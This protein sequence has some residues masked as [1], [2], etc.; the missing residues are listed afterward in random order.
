MT[1]RMLATAAL[2][3]VLAAACGKYG[4]PVRLRSEPVAAGSSVAT[5]KGGAS[6]PEES[7]EKEK[8]P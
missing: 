1:R 2:V 6:T 5:E 8:R 4:P 7:D 3:G